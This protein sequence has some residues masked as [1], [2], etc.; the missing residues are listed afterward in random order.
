M[1]RQLL[2]A[3]GVAYMKQRTLERLV[4]QERLL[5]RNETFPDFVKQLSPSLIQ[6]AVDL[7]PFSRGEIFQDIFAALILQD[8]EAGYF[9]E[10]GAA[11]GIE[12]SNTWLFEKHFG[13]KGILA[14]P[15]HG[16]QEK[17]RRNRN[18]SI[19]TK[20]VWRE[21][22]SSIDFTEARD[23]GLSTLSRYAFSDSHADQRRSGKTYSVPTISLN[24]L[25]N[26]NCS[27]R[28]IDFMSIDTE[29]SELE[30]LS[31]FDFERWTMGVLCVEHNYRPD[32]EDIK[33]LL[34]QYGYNRVP[35]ELSR[36]DDWY[37]SESL[38]EKMHQ[39]L[40]IVATNLPTSVFGKT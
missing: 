33:E 30:I 22:N 1:L 27:P 4:S 36:F 39:T 23:G 10:F 16:W 31:S 19:S 32:R 24:D 8:V 5:R 38:T 15:A 25:L 34:S 28:H 2:S 18:A 7:L 3:A 21:S 20:C 12:G 35:S 11:D 37:V 14:E 29:G 40:S 26:E 17:L 6:P 13:W 9:V